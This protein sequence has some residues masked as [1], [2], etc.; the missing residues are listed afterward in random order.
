MTAV[1]VTNRIAMMIETATPIAPRDE[2][3]GIAKI[4]PTPIAPIETSAVAMINAITPH[5]I[6]P[7]TWS[8]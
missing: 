4:F 3:C 1:M 7:M 2:A 6:Q 5:L 8:W